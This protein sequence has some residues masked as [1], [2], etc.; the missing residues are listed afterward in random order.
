MRIRVAVV[1]LA[2][3]CACASRPKE[4]RDASSLPTPSHAATTAYSH[5]IR[6][7]LDWFAAANPVRAT[8]L[9]F[10]KH[11]A[12][13]QEV[14]QEALDRK[15]EALRGWLTR[16]EQVNCSALSGDDAVDGV[17][18]ENALRAELMELEEERVWRRNP[19]AYVGLVSGGLS[20]LSSRDF[21]PLS[22]RMMHMRSRMNDIPRV[23]EAAKVNLQDVPRLWAE[24][25]IR[26]A[27][28]TQ[29]YL[30][31]DLPRA[32]EAQGAD[33]LPPAERQAFDAARAKALE[34]MEAFTAWLEQDLLPRA[35]GDFR[36]GRERFEKKLALEEHVTLNADQLRDINERAI[37]EY[38][39]WVA[40]ETAKVDPTKSP[41]EVMAAL[42]KDHP[43]AEELIPLARKQLVE[44]QRFVREKDIL[45]LPSDSLPSV[46]ET[47]P[48]ERLGFASMDTP[49]PFESKAKEA[50]YNITNVESE[51]SSEEKAQHLTYFNRAGL[52]GITVHE[53]MPGH[54]VQLLYGAKI[55]TDVRK[56]FTPASVVEGWAHYAEQMMVD[57]GLGEGDPAV[58]L[59]QLRRALQ[60]HAR[61]YAALALH[62]YNEPV[63]AVAK[64]YAEIAYFEPFPALREV[65][66]GTSN[67]TYLYYALG[68]MQI[69]KLREDYKKH[70][71][72]SGKTF[73]LKDFHDRF[74]QL[75]LPVALA[76]KVL[77]PGDASPSLE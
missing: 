51:W 31:V 12:H 34:Q 13:L 21:A 48:Y 4:G 26:D 62:V 43:Q 73:V 10:H 53:A 58:R 68:R 23:L 19:G 41:A 14:S 45:T 70:L 11:D 46:R 29:V 16:L 27:R 15:A 67:P 36:L 55:P 63:E 49:G 72:A 24:Q 71:E 42:V 6:E 37:R 7:Y 2:S 30:R 22:E 54:F 1:L 64:R 8:R 33:K 59:G 66:R 17:V 39:A 69:L 9:G 28:G 50:Y 52:L 38:Q 5:F 3:V 40:R 57:E 75:G 35:T 20:S 61:W 65:E 25:A 77:I 56:V 32:L 47:P 76:R 74:L 44:L 60:R 18:L